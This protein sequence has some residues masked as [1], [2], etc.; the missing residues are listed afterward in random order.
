MDHN[1]ETLFALAKECDSPVAA[2]LREQVDYYLA[3]SDIN[4]TVE[5]ASRMAGQA[6]RLIVSTVTPTP[7]VVDI[8]EFV[9]SEMFGLFGYGLSL[10]DVGLVEA[11]IV[12]GFGFT[13]YEC[14]HLYDDMDW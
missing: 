2:R 6:I 4:L 3:M 11:H 9:E 8:G 13:G 14:D 12:A 10:S 1:D 7:S 5:Q